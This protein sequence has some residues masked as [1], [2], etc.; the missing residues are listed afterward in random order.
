MITAARNK[1]PY[2]NVLLAEDNPVNAL[3]TRT[4]LEKSDHSVHHVTNGQAVL[5]YIEKG[6]RPDLIIMDV[7]MPELDG[8]ETARWIRSGKL[9]RDIPILALTANAS[10][11]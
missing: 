3:L 1:S 2:L 4:L 11:A 8:L 6:G 10:S 7:Q 5:D 9:F